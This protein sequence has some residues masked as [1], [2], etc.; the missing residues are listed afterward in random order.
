MPN[1]RDIQAGEQAQILASSYLLYNGLLLT[2]VLTEEFSFEEVRTPDQ[3]QV[4]YNKIT[5]K[6][7]AILDKSLNNFKT[8]PGNTSSII[9]GGDIAF[10]DQNLQVIY[11]QLM[12]DRGVLKYAMPGNEVI[13]SP[14]LVPNTGGQRY[15]CDAMQGP[16]PLYCQITQISGTSS[17]YV[18]FGIETWQ[19]KCTDGG[20]LIRSHR[21]SMAHDVDGETWLTTRIV[22]G[23]LHFRPEWLERLQITP[24]RVLREWAHPVP[25]GFKR[26]NVKIQASPNGMEIAYSFT[27]SEEVLP[28]GS[29]SPALKLQAEFSISS[30]LAEGKPALTQAACHISAVGP[31]SQYRFN[32]LQMAL[33]IALRKI[34]KPGLAAV[35]DITI[36]YSLT[37][38]FVDVTMRAI[39]K[40]VGLGLEGMA[41]PDTGLLAIDDQNDLDAALLPYRP[42]GEPSQAKEP[43]DA[44]APAMTDHGTVGTFAGFIVAS[45]LINGCFASSKPEI[46]NWNGSIE[47]LSDGTIIRG[48]TQDGDYGGGS[49]FA[50]KDNNGNAVSFSLTITPVLTIQMLATGLSNAYVAAVGF[51]EEWSMNTRYHTVHQ[52]AVLPTGAGQSSSPGDFAT[53][54][55]PQV[56]TLGDP[57]TIKTVDWSIAWVGPSASQIML[58]SPDTGD[59]NDILL[60]EDI[61]PAAPGFCNSS[62]KAW[63]VSG[64]YKYVSLKLRTSSA[65]VKSQYN[66]VDDGFSLGKAITDPSARAE[67]IIGQS[68]FI[69]GYSPSFVG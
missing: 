68:R 18:R 58:P 47:N 40:P 46:Q 31:K 59:A 43:F 8:S 14:E 44:L 65:A 54:K 35:T 15:P 9:R 5:I 20:K 4:L 11:N 22:T 48:L 16:K 64:T 41:I 45:G 42:A 32:L 66:Y 28:L 19:D 23:Q 29:N 52:R 62:N 27:D 6:V 10:S 17:F 26:H 55:R 21:W 38:M 1:I 7:S 39:W 60:E 2:D 69:A 34:Q 61:S 56:G 12:Q 30:S 63:R 25:K 57:Y 37:N 24:D 13:E 36:N 33:R 53:Y 67:N 51:Y 49:D 3:S 50:M